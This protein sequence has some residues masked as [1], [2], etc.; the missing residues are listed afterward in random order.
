MQE[1]VGLAEEDGVGVDIEVGQLGHLAGVACS[2]GLW[3]ALLGATLA[4]LPE[5]CCERLHLP[6]GVRRTINNQLRTGTDK[7]NLT[8]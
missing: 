6:H 5:D 3:A 4:E 8:V 2:S 7:G 1:E